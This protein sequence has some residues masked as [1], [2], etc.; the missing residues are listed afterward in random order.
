MPNRQPPQLSSNSTSNSGVTFG[1]RIFFLE[2]CGA[3]FR[4]YIFLLGGPTSNPSASRARQSVSTGSRADCE[5]PPQP[6]DSYTTLQRGDKRNE[7]NH[8]NHAAEDT[9]RKRKYWK[10]PQSLHSSSCCLVLCCVVYESGSSLCLQSPARLKKLVWKSLK[11]SLPAL[12]AISQD[13]LRS[14]KWPALRKGP[15]SSQQARSFRSVFDTS[16]S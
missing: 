8:A 16:Q 4:Q 2:F 5:S 14:G 12:S 11:F 15:G 1:H 13:L 9:P 7:K 3:G 10:F 6:R